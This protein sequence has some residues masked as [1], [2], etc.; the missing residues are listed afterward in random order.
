MS[1]RGRWY[2]TDGPCPMRDHIWWPTRTVHSP[3]DP[4]RHPCLSA[5]CHRWQAMPHLAQYHRWSCPPTK[6]RWN[7]LSVWQREKCRSSSLRPECLYN[8]SSTQGSRTSSP[9]RPRLLRR[10]QRTGPALS[11]FVRANRKRL[12]APRWRQGQGPKQQPRMMK[13]FLN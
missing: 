5:K 6:P 1:L 3:T 7:R 8:W 11:H 2:H 13:P 12:P 10:P 9:I 4:A